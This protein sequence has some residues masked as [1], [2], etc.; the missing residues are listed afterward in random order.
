MIAVFSVTRE[1][2]RQEWKRLQV[3]GWS[4]NTW[5]ARRSQ[6]R[7]FGEFC[8]LYELRTI[9]A[10]VE[11]IC[12]YITYLTKSVKYVT[13][14]NYLSG[15]WTMHDYYGVPHVD[16]TSFLI[17]MTLQGAKRLLGAEADRAAPILPSDLREMYKCIDVRATGDLVFWAAVTLS[18][19]CLL[20]KSHVTA[21]PHVLR[22]GDVSFESRGMVVTVRSSKTIQSRE[23]KFIIPVVESPGCVLCPVR[24]VRKL[25]RR[26]RLSPCDP[27]FMEV[28]PQARPLT[29]NGYNNQLKAVCAKA[30]LIGQF[31]T[32]SLR[33]GGA[34]FLSSIGIPLQD[35]RVYGDWRSWSV[36]LYLS[37]TKDSRWEKDKYVSEKLIQS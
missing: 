3:Q 4:N 7:R 27:L 2:L 14:V 13:I 8:E 34:T 12:L 31:S 26:L 30:G 37:D 29:Y 25:M 11:T 21:S 16:R 10:T 19:R 28:S 1:G 5:R 9:P 6:W 23:R 24:W 15:V 33:R 18:F 32:H 22:A 35:I 36:L 17:R 20:R